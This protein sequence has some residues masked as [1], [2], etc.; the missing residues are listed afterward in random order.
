M[1]LGQF[2]G[3]VAE[4]EETSNRAIGQV[5]LRGPP[6]LEGDPG[7]AVAETPS[8]V[9]EVEPDARVPMLEP[10]SA[11]AP[12]PISVVVLWPEEVRGPGS[13]AV[14]GSPHLW[15]GGSVPPRVADLGSHERWRPP[16]PT[17]R[18][19]VPM[20]GERLPG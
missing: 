8:P 13:P 20:L 7:V 1:A 3:L 18:R 12:R 2:S 4:L 16:D 6:W 14:C 5:E 19:A 15:P 9:E 17:L 10:W 11:V